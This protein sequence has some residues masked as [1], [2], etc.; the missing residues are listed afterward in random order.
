MCHS[1]EKTLPKVLNDLRLNVDF[2]NLSILPAVDLSA[3]FVTIDH[4][5]LLNRLHTWAGLS[6]TIRLI[7]IPRC[8]CKHCI[9][10]SS[11][12]R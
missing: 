4:E 9:V 12:C 7:Q 8:G 1:T 11:V 2:G 10:L 6:V 5:I 3:A